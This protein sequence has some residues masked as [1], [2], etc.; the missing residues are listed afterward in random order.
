[1]F[2]IVT[3]NTIIKEVEYN[4]NYVNGLS[5]FMPFVWWAY[6]LTV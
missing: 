5:L 1:M 3:N 2:L 4:E 6:A